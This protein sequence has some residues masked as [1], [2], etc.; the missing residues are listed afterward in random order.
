MITPITA[1][2]TFI[3]TKKSISHLFLHWDLDRATSI[4]KEDFLNH[5]QQLTH[6]ILIT[7]SITKGPLI[8]W[9][10][11]HWSRSHLKLYKMQ[12]L[13]RYKAERA[14]SNKNQFLRLTKKIKLSQRKLQLKGLCTRGWKERSRIWTRR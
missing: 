11:I 1:S 10:T 2:R 14:S 8:M 3:T 4:W 5:C 12:N 7:L 6:L 9:Q 13:I